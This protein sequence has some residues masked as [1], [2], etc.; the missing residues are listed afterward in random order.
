MPQPSPFL[1]LLQIHLD[2]IQI[3]P[4]ISLLPN[5]LILNILNILKIPNNRRLMVT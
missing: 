2:P 3:N 5:L 4:F 1:T